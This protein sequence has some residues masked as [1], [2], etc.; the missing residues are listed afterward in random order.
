MET[1]QGEQLLNRLCWEGR[2]A[3]ATQ[4][5]PNPDMEQSSH[6]SPD[7]AATYAAVGSSAAFKDDHRFEPHRQIKP[8][9]NTPQSWSLFH[10]NLYLFH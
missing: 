6:W 1:E 8:A 4:N 9:E 10:L 3:A 2:A 5:H 7:T